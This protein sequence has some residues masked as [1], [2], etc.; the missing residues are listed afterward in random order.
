MTKLL[1]RSLLAVAALAA[2]A[3]RAQSALPKPGALVR[4][5]AADAPGSFTR[6][7]LLRLSHDTLLLRPTRAAADSL[8]IAVAEIDRL[9]VAT[10]GRRVDHARLIALFAAAG[11]APGVYYGV[12]GRSSCV[13]CQHHDAPAGRALLIGGAGAL[14]GGLLGHALL[15]R[16][17]R[18]APVPLP[19]RGVAP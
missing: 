16:S 2:G 12:Q 4:V 9:E 7:E 18:W 13:Q 10:R 8:R 14:L 6:G 1:I 5:S 11:A 15:P 19:R 17:V 3:A